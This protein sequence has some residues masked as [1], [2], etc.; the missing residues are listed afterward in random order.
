[1]LLLVRREQVVEEGQERRRA[2]AD[3]ASI[4]FDAPGKIFVSM[5]NPM[6]ICH[7][8]IHPCQVGAHVRPD[9]QFGLTPGDVNGIEVLEKN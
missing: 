1:M 5:V 7:N 4:Q 2:A 9:G 3:Y 6:I 8:H